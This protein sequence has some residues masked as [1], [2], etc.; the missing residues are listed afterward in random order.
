VDVDLVETKLDEYTLSIKDI[1][2]KVEKELPKAKLIFNDHV[3]E[4]KKR[5]EELENK[6]NVSVSVI[7]NE[8]TDIDRKVVQ[9]EEKYSSVNEQLP[10]IKKEILSN[11]SLLEKNLKEEISFVRIKLEEEISHKESQ[12]LDTFKNTVSLQN[13][14]LEKLNEELPKQRSRITDAELDVKKAVKD[15]TEIKN[16]RSLFKR[17]NEVHREVKTVDGLIEQNNEKL[18]HKL[19]EQNHCYSW[20]GISL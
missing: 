10:K 6:Q 20:G 1:K 3:Y 15:I 5:L 9:L 8:L 12:I 7:S 19:E 2:E 13:L 14:E 4:N 16:D 17:L 18:K 11:S